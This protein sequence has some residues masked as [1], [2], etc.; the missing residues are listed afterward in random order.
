MHFCVLSMLL[1]THLLCLL[2]SQKMAYG[3]SL[4]VSE[5]HMRV[6]KRTG[7]W[8]V[9]NRVVLNAEMLPWFHYKTG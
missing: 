4:N 9:G 6:I 8:V 5:R 7:M 3:E 2:C 1:Q